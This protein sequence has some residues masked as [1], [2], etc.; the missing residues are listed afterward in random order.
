MSAHTDQPTVLWRPSEEACERATVTRFA[1]WVAETRGV[2]VSGD[3]AVVADDS[4]SAAV[5][6][7]NITNP[8]SPQIVGS[9]TIPGGSAKDLRASGNIAYV[10]AYTGGFQVVSFATPASPQII[11]GLP[12]SAPTGFV[13]RDVE[14]S[15]QFALAAEQLFPNVVPIV[16]VSTPAS[17]NF[18]ATLDFAPLGDYAG[19]GIALTQQYVYMTGESFIVGDDNGTTGNTRLFIGQY[20][21]IEDNA[22]IAPSVSITAPANNGT[23]V[24][25]TTVPFKVNATDDIAVAGV[26]FLVNGQVVFTD[27]AAP[28]EYNLTVPAGAPVITLGA[29]AI[30][31]GGNIGAAPDIHVNVIP[32]PLTTVGGRVVDENSQPVAGAAV[33]VLGRTAQSAADGAFSITNVPTIKGDLVVEASFTRPDTTLL[34]GRSS[35]TAPV[36]GGTTSVGDIVLRAGG[37]LALVSVN[38][39]SRVAVIDLKTNTLKTTIPVGS[40]PLGAT[41]TPDGRIGVVCNFNGGTMTFLDLTVDPPVVTGTITTSPEI[42]FPESITVTPDGRFGIVADGDGESDVVSVDL[43]LRTVVGKVAGVPSN[44]GIAVTPD[45]SLVL[46]LSSNTNQVSV[47]TIDANGALADTH[48]RVTLAGVAGGPR[49][50]AVTPNGRRAIVTDSSKSIVTILSISGST[51]TNVGA[52]G[53]LG[54]PQIFNTSGVAITPDGKKVYIS[55]SR[56]STIAV[57]AIDA[58]DN[59]TDTGK[60]IAVP[61]GTPNTFY[62]VPGIAVTQDGTRLLISG[63][64]TGRVS[65]LD[66]ATDTLLPA[67]INVGSGPTGIGMSGRR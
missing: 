10:V 22:G 65:I 36:A 41:V 16:D 2:D 23:A 33:S 47:L 31:F 5:R 27:T 58:N 14:L 11:G 63:Y 4:P 1:R 52:V 37:N 3:F 17:P 48:Q 35:P 61:N 45:G 62:G 26:N 54:S 25:G 24:E 38:G 32:D 67:S 18:R 60:R 39:T 50:I 28:F 46:V 30:D 13:P 55:N 51:V 59:V 19:T 42:P 57:L 53:S 9:V 49:S 66:T 29:T 20:L 15:G 12:G 34:T 43:K 6:V 21:A 56:D 44:Q 64:N 8:A 7:I 40:G